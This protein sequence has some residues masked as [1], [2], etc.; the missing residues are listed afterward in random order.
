LKKT[1]IGLACTAGAA[2]LVP[3]VLVGVLGAIGFSPVG[4]VSGKYHSMHRAFLV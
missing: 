2:A 3:I 1:A 4:P